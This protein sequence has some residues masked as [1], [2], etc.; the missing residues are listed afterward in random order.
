MQVSG[1]HG[2][3]RQLRASGYALGHIRPRAFSFHYCDVT[4][5]GGLV[6]HRNLVYPVVTHSQSA[7]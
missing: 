7:I 4:H 2:N 6:A 1:T 5:F 3:Q